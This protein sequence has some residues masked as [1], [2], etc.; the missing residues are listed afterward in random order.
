MCYP[1][2]KN[3]SLDT[4][5]LNNYRLISLLSFL[6]KLLE[7][8]VAKQRVQHL[9]SESLFV[10]VQSAYRSSHSTETTLLKVM[11]DLLLAVDKGDAAIIALLDQ[12]AAFDTVEYVILLDRLSARF[13]ISGIAHSWFSSYLCTRSQSVSVNGVFFQSPSPFIRRTTGLCAW[14]HSLYSVQL[15]IPRNSFKYWSEWSLLRRRCT[16]L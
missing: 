14:T 4:E 3:H 5:L 9:E 12:S 7:R 2:L 15:P 13:G 11:N 16:N 6:S 8:V 1:L 10:P